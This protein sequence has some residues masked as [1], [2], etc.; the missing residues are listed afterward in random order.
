M[1]TWWKHTNKSEGKVFY[2]ITN[3]ND[4]TKFNKSVFCIIFK[5]NENGKNVNLKKSIL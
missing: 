2:N 4:L 3:I 5:L 1:L